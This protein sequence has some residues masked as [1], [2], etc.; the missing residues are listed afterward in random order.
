MSQF[1]YFAPVEM[2]SIAS[3]CLYVSLFVGSVAYLDNHTSKF[4]TFSVH[5]ICGRGSVLF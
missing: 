2:R 3:A 4:T 1:Y 5:V